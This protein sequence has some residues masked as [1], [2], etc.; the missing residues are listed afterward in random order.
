MRVKTFTLRGNPPI[1]EFPRQVTWQAQCFVRVANERNPQSGHFHALIR[2]RDALD[3]VG[4][5]SRLHPE[6]NMT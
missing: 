4:L 1:I 2:D 3:G 5:L 6:Y